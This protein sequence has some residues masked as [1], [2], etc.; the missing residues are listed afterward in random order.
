WGRLDPPAA[1]QWLVNQPPGP[2]RDAFAAEFVRGTLATDPAAAL[3]W[4]T[5]I[6]DDALRAGRLTELYGQWK[7]R[8]AD[9]AT[10]WLQQAHVSDEER[11]ILAGQKTP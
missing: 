9:A 5:T 4:T 10:A 1:S 8:D 7:Q 2:Q 6:E 11:E 3:T